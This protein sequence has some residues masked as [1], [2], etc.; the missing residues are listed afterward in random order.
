MTIPTLDLF[1]NLKLRPLNFYDE[2]NYYPV[3]FVV[4]HA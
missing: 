1:K 3:T 4:Q 2:K